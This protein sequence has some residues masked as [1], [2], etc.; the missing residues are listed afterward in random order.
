MQNR[1]EE[2][3]QFLAEN[4]ADMVCRVGFDLVMQYTS[5]S[6]ERIL[7]WKPEEMVGKG[8]DAFVFP[9]DLPTVGAAH[10][11]LLA[12]GVD[13]VPTEVRMRRKDG[14]YAW[15]EVNARMAQREGDVEASGIVLIMRDVSGRLRLPREGEPSQHEDLTLHKAFSMTPVPM[16]IATLA[17]VRIID[18]NDAFVAATGYSFDGLRGREV[19]EVGVLDDS[20][21][22]HIG[23]ALGKTDSVRSMEVQLRTRD[24]TRLDCLLSVEVATVER[25]RCMLAVF[26]D[27]SERKR[28]EA[29]LMQAIENVMQDS[30]RFGQAVIEKL[31]QLRQPRRIAQPEAELADL[32]SREREVLGLVCEGQTDDDI[33]VML[34]LSRNTVRNHVSRIYTKIGVHRRAGAVVWARTR[35]VLERELPQKQK[36]SRR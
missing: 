26:Q 21:C 9:D 15:M 29:E 19:T 12:N 33:S 7:G 27:V 4:S 36:K 35:G 3:Y 13:P 17:G 10:K 31:A 2:D 16:I 1:N 11:R 8:P 23:A 22:R 18:V 14:S 20:T 28:S 30:R 34:G 24:G 5:P 6:C 25:Q 32:T